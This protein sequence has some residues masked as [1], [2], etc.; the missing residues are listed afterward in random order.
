[1]NNNNNNNN[2]NKIKEVTITSDYTVVGGGMAGICTAITAAREGLKVALVQ[3]RPVL[4]GNASSE[5]RVWALGATAGMGNNNRWGR[6]GGVIDEILTEN[7][8]RNA[9]GNAYLFDALLL[10]KVLDEEN[11]QLFLNT[12]INSSETDGKN[13]ITSVS[14]YNSNNE[15]F[16]TFK[17]KFFSDSSGDGLVGYTSGAE[18]TITPET[19]EDFNESL[20][21]DKAYGHCL[22]NSIMFS[23]KD[24]GQ[25]VKYTAPNFALKDITKLPKYKEMKLLEE[26]DCHFWWFEYGGRLDTIRDAEEIK[27]ELKKVVYGAWDH[28]KN[29][30]KFP[31]AKNK[32]L[33]WIGALP[34][35]RDARRFY[36][37]Y[38][39]TQDDVLLVK[40]HKDNIAHGGWSIDLHPSDGIYSKLPSSSHWHPKSVYAIPYRCLYSRNIS[41][42]FLG[43][44]LISVSHIAFGTTRLMLTGAVNGQATGMATAMCV[45]YNLEPKDILEDKYLHELQQRLIAKGH[46]IPNVL[47]ALEN[48]LV[49]QAKISSNDTLPFKGFT[50]KSEDYTRLDKAYAF[51]FPVNKGKIPSF[52]LN[53]KAFNKDNVNIQIRTTESLDNFTPHTTLESFDVAL[54]TGVQDIII[55]PTASVNE[56]CYIYITLGENPDILFNSTSELLT[57]VTTVY[58]PVMELFNKEDKAQ[59]YE[60]WQ[61]MRHPNEF[62]I[63]IEFLEEQNIFQPE[64]ILK[65]QYRPVISSNAWVGKNKHDSQ[66]KIQWDKEINLK[67]GILTMFFDTNSSQNM[68][69]TGKNH[70]YH[71]LS[72]CIKDYTITNEKNEVIVSVKDNHQ[73]VNHHNLGTINFSELTI[74]VN[75]TW[76]NKPAIFGICLK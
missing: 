34:G 5:I 65:G 47:P 66:L 67:N 26:G 9:E 61:A 7:V 37:D 38:M 68:E 49:S 27:Y 10:D 51:L 69:T 41:N 19:K 23:I 24:M 62:N 76:G 32:T 3:D 48:N 28:I 17:S 53:F 14:G 60:R 36:G 55:K 74:T 11:I 72:Y 29:S 43:G 12:S 63:A 40:H 30:G 73:A 22:G 18:H 44:R 71:A 56:N 4:G 54:E 25:E 16:Y 59:S 2:Q 46:Y 20:I 58:N 35:K 1:M 33:D 31:E 52:K 64:N 6:E 45:E 75:D 39:L 21:R 42:L 57:A 70:K 8:H 15:T 50:Q 13:K